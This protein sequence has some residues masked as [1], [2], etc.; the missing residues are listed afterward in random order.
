MVTPLAIGEFPEQFRNGKQFNV[1]RRRISRFCAAPGEFANGFAFEIFPICPRFRRAVPSLLSSERTS[2]MKLTTMAAGAPKQFLARTFH[3]AA[4]A[5][6]SALF[7]RGFRRRALNM[8]LAAGLLSALLLPEPGYAQTCR[9]TTI[10]PPQQDAIGIPW[11]PNFTLPATITV[12]RDAPAGTIIA[13]SPTLTAPYVDRQ[14]LCDQTPNLETIPER[15]A[16]GG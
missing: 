10:S 1:M 14:V 13:S 12:P 9:W 11:R 7:R 16:G 5:G 15:A 4:R 8:L 2:I 6:Q 3:R